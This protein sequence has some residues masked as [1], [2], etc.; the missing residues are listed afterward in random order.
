MAS[1]LPKNRG[2]A[3]AFIVTGPILSAGACWYLFGRLKFHEAPGLMRH[4]PQVY[5]M[6]IGLVISGIVLV[7]MGLYVLRRQRQR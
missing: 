3:I 2:E 1:L 5:L 4:F 6:L 7:G